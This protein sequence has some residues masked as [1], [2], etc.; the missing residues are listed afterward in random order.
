[1]RALSKV[2]VAT[3]SSTI[4]GPHFLSDNDYEAS[5]S[6]QRLTRA[7]LGAIDIYAVVTRFFDDFLLHITADCGV[8]Q[9]VLVACGLDTRPFRLT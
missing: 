8:R 4:H 9:V 2:V 3:D 7:E 5:L 6:E 1:M